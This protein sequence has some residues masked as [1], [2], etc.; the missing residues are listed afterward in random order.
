MLRIKRL[1]RND[2]IK[3]HAC[4]N[5]NNTNSN[6]YGLKK[7]I[8][9]FIS[10]KLARIFRPR[11]YAHKKSILNDYYLKFDY[12][13]HCL[14]Q[15]LLLKYFDIEIQRES[16]EKE[17]FKKQS[18]NKNHS[19]HS[20][21]ESSRYASHDNPTYSESPMSKQITISSSSTPFIN[22]SFNYNGCET[23]S[24][25][26]SIFSNSNCLSENNNDSY[27]DRNL[28]SKVLDVKIKE[29]LFKLKLL[30]PKSIYQ[31]QVL[32]AESIYSIKVGN[33]KYEF[34]Q[35]LK[36][37][38]EMNNERKLD[39]NRV[40]RKPKR[41]SSITNNLAKSICACSK[42]RRKSSM[43]R[44]RI[45]ATSTEYLNRNLTKTMP[46][47]ATS[48][49]NLNELIQHKNFFKIERENLELK[50]EK[51][52]CALQNDILNKVNELQM[53]IRIEQRL[54]NQSFQ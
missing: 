5:S 24:F 33:I 51:I 14:N 39:Y 41:S 34:E 22:Y 28:P 49:N 8:N 17:M 44:D 43:S 11:T 31:T 47:S 15:K 21:V 30:H 32:M 52:M 20:A 29:L 9:L 36:Q 40:Q 46:I 23:T 48:L 54:W 10:K 18:Q 1:N 42:F 53:Q 6:N 35:Q 38:D 25:D 50:Y 37:F 12:E 4:N 19:Y 16:T 2:L 3:K 13:N 45:S 27:I 26:R 7:R